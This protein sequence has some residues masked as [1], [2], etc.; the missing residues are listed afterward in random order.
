MVLPGGG[1]GDTTGCNEMPLLLPLQA[2][3]TGCHHLSQKVPCGRGLDPT[4][5]PP[6]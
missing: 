4:E 5:V 3:V 2:P 6:S 1:R